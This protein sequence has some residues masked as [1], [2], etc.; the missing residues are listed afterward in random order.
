MAA[1]SASE[2][3]AMGE[4]FGTGCGSAAGTAEHRF[5]LIDSK[6]TDLA[7]SQLDAVLKRTRRV[8]DGFLAF[9]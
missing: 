9:H 7:P 6:V 2:S 3:V 4:A 8:D 1:R 5:L